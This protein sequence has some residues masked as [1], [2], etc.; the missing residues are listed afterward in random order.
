MSFDIQKRAI[1]NRRIFIIGI[2]QFFVFGTIFARL[3]FLQIFQHKKY[4]NSAQ[5]NSVKLL[6]RI[7]KRGKI[8][9][10]N[11]IVLADSEISKAIIFTG[12]INLP[13]SKATIK[14][15][16]RIIYRG[17]EEKIN[18]GLQKAIRF[19]K[20]N[21]YTHVMLYK[22]LLFDEFRRFAFYIPLLK[23]VEITEV[24]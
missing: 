1:F 14:E 12:N 13:E 10:R 4:K 7:P 5:L 8:Y 15:V 17:D 20:N 24:N 23:N 22:N 19:A 16:Y 9:D 2:I 6:F 18:L 11:G 3:I 21:P